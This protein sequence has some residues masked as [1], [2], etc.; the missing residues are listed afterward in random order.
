MEIEVKVSSFL[1]PS[2]FTPFYVYTSTLAERSLRVDK[3]PKR[4]EK[5]KF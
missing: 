2:F 5:A 4:I 3:R 1:K